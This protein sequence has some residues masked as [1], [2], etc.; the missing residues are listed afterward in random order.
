VSFIGHFSA[1]QMVTAV[2]KKIV[3]FVIG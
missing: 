2:G 1:E 3:S